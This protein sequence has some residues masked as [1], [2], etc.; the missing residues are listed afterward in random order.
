MTASDAHEEMEEVQHDIRKRE[1]EVSLPKNNQNCQILL[2]NFHSM[3]IDIIQL[4]SRE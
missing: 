2:K 1:E 4:F 3:L